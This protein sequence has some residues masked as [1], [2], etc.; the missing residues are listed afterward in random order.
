M[1]RTEET[2]RAHDEG[3][4]PV[5]VPAFSAH[6]IRHTVASQLVRVETNVK[7]VQEILGHASAKMTLDVYAEAMPED[8]ADTMRKFESMTG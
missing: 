7:A 8:K 5:L 4:E 6:S 1:R 2:E 3:R